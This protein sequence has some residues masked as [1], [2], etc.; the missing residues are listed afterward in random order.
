MDRNSCA[1]QTGIA[2]ITARNTKKI[3]RYQRYQAELVLAQEAMW[4][5]QGMHGFYRIWQRQD[6]NA[7]APYACCFRIEPYYCFLSLMAIEQAARGLT[8]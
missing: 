2:S 6:E 4:R 7:L 1:N 8:M 5:T 3:D